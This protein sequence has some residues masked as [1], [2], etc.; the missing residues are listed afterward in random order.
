[1][2]NR[3]EGSG[4]DSEWQAGDRRTTKDGTKIF[5]PPKSE[6]GTRDIPLS[7][8]LIATLKAWKLATQE[9]TRPGLSDRRR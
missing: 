7:Q 3:A 5:A 4:D 6:A 2:L 9:R 8:M 1:M